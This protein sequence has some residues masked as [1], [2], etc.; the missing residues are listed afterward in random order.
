MRERTESPTHPVLQN[1]VTGD[2]VV[3]PGPV[4]KNTKSIQLTFINRF[5]VFRSSAVMRVPFSLS[6][7]RAP[8]GAS[9]RPCVHQHRGCSTPRHLSIGPKQRDLSSVV[10]ASFITPLPITPGSGPPPPVACP[11]DKSSAPGGSTI[12]SRPVPTAQ[13]FFY[14]TLHAKQGRYFSDI[15]LARATRNHGP[16]SAKPRRRIRTPGC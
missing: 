15:G 2:A 10:N 9:F 1:A 13:P 16:A 7:S 5:C 6:G 12:P 4:E 14:F 8:P 11:T 3:A